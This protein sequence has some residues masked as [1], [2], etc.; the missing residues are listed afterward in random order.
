MTTLR[1]RYLL[2]AALLA[3][4]AA[5]VE[6]QDVTFKVFQFPANMIPRMSR[7]DAHWAAHGV[8]AQNYH[9]LPSVPEKDSPRLSVPG[10]TS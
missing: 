3:L 7:A 1:L 2:L 4:P 9:V 10:G 6:R 8:Q 5:A